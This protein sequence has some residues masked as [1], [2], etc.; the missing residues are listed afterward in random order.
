MNI[1]ELKDEIERDEGRV[2]EVYKCTMGVSTFGVGHAIKESDP[3]WGLVIGAKISDERIDQAFD[4]DIEITLEECCRLYPD[5][6]DLP[7]EV[8]LIIA[9]MMFNLGS[10]RLAK[11]KGMKAG[12]DARDWDKAA[13]EMV[14]SR[15]Y[16]QVGN[17]SKR[18]VQRM[19]A[20]A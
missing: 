13:D 12:V 11:F 1:R 15:W 20:L 5:F 9:N 16:H 4:Q 6:Y 7:D 14:D 17:R 10:T 18:L 2:N 8:Q 3:E 19:R